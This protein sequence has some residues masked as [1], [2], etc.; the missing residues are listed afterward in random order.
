MERYHKIPS[1]FKR[2]NR[3]KF[4]QE[5]STPEIC[6]LQNIEWQMEEKLDG[7]NIR[8][9]WDGET[10]RFGGKTDN[11]Q[12]PVPLLN[13]LQDECPLSL[14]R[15]VFKGVPTCLYG[16]GIGPKIQKGGELYG[17][18]RFVLFD[19]GIGG[20]WL[21]REDVVDVAEKIG[22]EL[23]TIHAVGPLQKAI[24]IVLN[25]FESTY[26]ERAAEGLVLRPPVQLFDRMGERIIT[27]VKS[28]DHC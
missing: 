10:V 3:G 28:K 27:K 20:Y 4:T 11:A 22:C 19:V 1:I 5:F 17:D 2:D 14:F 9:M 13:V 25:G 6:A 16:E 18:L 21:R 26:G 7:T 12:I 8:I 24:D 15:D 23:S